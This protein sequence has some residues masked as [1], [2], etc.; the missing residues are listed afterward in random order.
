[1][2]GICYLYNELQVCGKNGGGFCV[3]DTGEPV[4]TLVHGFLRISILRPR[5]LNPYLRSPIIR[6]YHE[7]EG[8]KEKIYHQ[9]RRLP[10]RDL[11]CRVMTN[12]DPEGRIFLSYPNTNN[13]FFFCSPL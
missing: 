9:D 8:R 7:C 12:G 4:C 6:I 10:S 1:M 2:R 11:T 13:G 5:L 3:N